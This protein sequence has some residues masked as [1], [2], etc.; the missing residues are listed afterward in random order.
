[1]ITN[2]YVALKLHDERAATLRAEAAHF[3]LA[4]PAVR[5]LQGRPS[6]RWWHRLSLGGYP[7]ILRPA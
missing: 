6:R 7:A 5:R 3:R 4:R 1:M 2:D